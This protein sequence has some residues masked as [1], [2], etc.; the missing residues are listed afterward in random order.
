MFLYLFSTDGGFEGS[1]QNL[2]KARQARQG[3]AGSRHRS[4][5]EGRSSLVSEQVC[6]PTIF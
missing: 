3:A 1:V 5:H 6:Q 4:G 2:T